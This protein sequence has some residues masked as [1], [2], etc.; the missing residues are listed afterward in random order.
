MK[1]LILSL[2]LVFTACTNKNIAIAHI[3]GIG[4]S[5][6]NG[7]A[8]FIETN[9][10]VKLTI[11]VHNANSDQLAI[12]IHEIGDC[13]SLDG[14]SAGSHWNPTN[15]EHGKWGVPP[16]HSGDIGNLLINKDGSGTLVVEDFFKRWSISNPGKSNIIGRA[17]IIHSGADDM[18]SQPSGAAGS[19]IG[20]GTIE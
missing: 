9:N 16:F 20:C 14:L 8:K 4:S 2:L 7:V 6:I 1:P 17:I 19:R 12:H 15:E 18:H 5:P 11:D 3:K 10:L 13:E